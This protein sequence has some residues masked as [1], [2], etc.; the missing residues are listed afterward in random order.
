VHRLVLDARENFERKLE[1]HQVAEMLLGQGSGWSVNGI[2]PTLDALSK[3]QVRT[4][5]VRADAAVPG[6]RC[7]VTGRLTLN[8][9]D[10]RGLGNAVPVPDIV[11]DA[12]EEALRQRIDLDVV[13]EPDAAETINGLA[14]LLRFR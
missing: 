7:A 2:A 5:L 13:F 9:R 10:C 1:R 14:A 4:L 11:D 8:A 3:G 12:I 6:F